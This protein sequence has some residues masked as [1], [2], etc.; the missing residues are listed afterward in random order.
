M[1]QVIDMTTRY[2][3]VAFDGKRTAIARALYQWDYGQILR[4]TDLEL[5]VAYEVHFA[6]TKTGNSVTQIGNADGV[7]IP[8]SVL[9]HSGSIYAWFY[10]HDTGSDGETRYEILI[11]VIQRA[12]PTNET[13]TPVQQDVITETIA[14]LDDAVERAEAAAALFVVDP[15]FDAESTNPVENR[16]VT[17]VVTDLTES[18]RDSIL[19]AAKTAGTEELPAGF[20]T[21]HGYLRA[22]SLSGAGN[23]SGTDG[24]NNNV[25]WMLAEE[26]MDVYV[27]IHTGTS[28]QIG[29]FRNSPYGTANRVTA[30]HAST[31]DVYPMPTADNPLHASAGQYITFSNYNGSGGLS[32]CY[33]ELYKLG[34]PEYKLK[35]TTELTETMTAEVEAMIA[36]PPSTLGLTDTQSAEVDS[37]VAAPPSTVALTDTQSGE[38]DAKIAAAVKAETDSLNA[39][40]G[41]QTL[42]GSWARGDW[43]G[44]SSHT[45]RAFRVRRT[46]AISFARDVILIANEGYMFGGYTENGSIGDWRSIYK[47][48]A[49]TPLKLNVRRAVEI[50]GSNPDAD[51]DTFAV[52]VLSATVVSPIN[53]YQPTWTDVSMFE[54]MG[55]GGD[56]YAGGG[57]IISGIRSLTWGKNLE[58]QAGIT[59]DIYAKSGTNVVQWSKSDSYGLLAL[60]AGEEC[61]LY[62]LQHGIN[63]TSTAAEIGT[64]ADMSA[65]P[66]PDTFYGRYAYSVQQIQAAFPKARIVLATITGSAYGLS[67]STY[68][69]VNTAIR[70]IAE[71][72]GVPCIEIVEDPFYRSTFYSSWTTSNHPTAPVAAGMAMAHRRLISKCIQANKDYFWH[73]GA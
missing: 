59:V 4:V 56:S 37:K 17:A 44:W 12:R 13:P 52:Q 67:Q 71:F 35:S 63:G 47:L 21:T 45:S 39:D 18:V 8:D 32:G 40:N 65:D 2:V 36:D 25:F 5:P 58:R 22:Q 31:S 46:T 27:R 61:G 64:P 9:Q 53:L 42:G 38:V 24:V 6:L 55:I 3:D 16:A 62:W 19:V 51:V 50:S 49:N 72:C 41:Y 1:R 69:D 28:R 33:W 11:P 60:L 14:A 26:D 48:P 66:Q 43:D 20:S 70:N 68:A 7:A 10:L 29:I 15:S 57:G 23:L 30:V 54:R 34:D 73:Y